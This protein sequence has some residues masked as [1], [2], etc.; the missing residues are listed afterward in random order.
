MGEG[1]PNS[2]NDYLSNHGWLNYLLGDPLK[3]GKV[4]IKT[5]LGIVF[6]FYAI[7]YIGYKVY[8]KN[9]GKSVGSKGE[10]I[11]EFFSEPFKGS[12]KVS[13]FLI[14]D[15][16]EAHYSSGVRTIIQK[17][18]LNIL[19]AIAFTAIMYV[20]VVAAVILSA[21]VE[22]S[23]FNQFTQGDWNEKVGMILNFFSTNVYANTTLLSLYG[24]LTVEYAKT[25]FLEG[26]Y[27]HLK[28][29]GI[30]LS[31][32]LGEWDETPKLNVPEVELVES[33]Q[34]VIK[35][36]INTRQVDQV[37]VKAASGYDLFGEKGFL[38]DCI[39]KPNVTWRILLMN[40]EGKGVEK[41]SES[42]NTERASDPPS[43]GSQS[44][45]ENISSIISKIQEIKKSNNL[46]IQVRLYDHTPQWRIFIFSGIAIVGS[47]GPGQRSDRVPHFIFENTNTSL[48][49][50]YEEMF[51]DI[52]HNSSKDAFKC[53]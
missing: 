4:E 11:Y 22:L 13:A 33:S 38:L 42:Y 29:T 24:L 53:E 6:I 31:V 21:G 25:R 35:S 7:C 47:F 16:V 14:Q 36:F 20:V 51:E 8:K 5:V 43:F 28:R 32:P 48:F 15:V 17:H 49:H 34:N 2:A 19:G 37:R 1:Q 23:I 46:N 40:P 41:R 9:K 39:K 12:M 52:W 27:W 10:L 26:K 50:G 18:L 3:T 45:K 30:L 44:Y